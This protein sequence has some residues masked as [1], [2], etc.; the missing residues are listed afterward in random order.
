MQKATRQ[1]SKDH[2]ARLVLRTIYNQDNISRADI[3][4]ATG[5]TR[6][7]VS[8]IVAGLIEDRFVLETGQGPSAGG[9]RPTLLAMA[10]DQHQVLAIDLGSQEFRGALVNL[11]GDIIEKLTFPTGGQQGEAA[12]ALVYE[13]IDA[14]LQTAGAPLLGIGVGTPGLTNPAAG[15][16]REAVN[17]GWSNMPRS[18]LLADRYRLPIYVANDSHM[19]ALGEYTFGPHKG[20]GNLLVIKI[21]QGVSAGIVLE[22]QPYF[23][24]GHSAGEIGHVVV[25]EGGAQCT[26]GNIGCLETTAS[27]RAIIRRAQGQAAR[28]P[29]SLLAQTA[30]VTWETLLSALEAGDEAARTVVDETG[31][32]LGVAVANLI[33]TLNIHQIVIAGRVFQ[34]G[35][36]LLASTFSEARRRALP[37]MVDDTEITYSNLGS[38]VV[39]LGSSAMILKNELGVI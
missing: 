35:P 22:G 34:L 20:V 7:T 4:R 39:I 11:R 26:C 27:T 9:K 23:G 14:L 36:L 24:D 13:L 6:P 37:A 31:R 18:D 21:G 2:N 30:P 12:L 19:A 28:C 33:A 16:I 25:E 29:D 38:D 5:L 15:V 3:S 32:F 17:L 8:R 10:Q 1:Q